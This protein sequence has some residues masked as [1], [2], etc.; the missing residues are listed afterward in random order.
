MNIS[1]LNIDK[2]IIHQI[3][4]RDEEGNKVE[5]TRGL[6]FITFDEDALQG[7]KSRVID[8]LGDGSKAVKMKILEH[9][10]SYVPFIA[11]NV[12]DKEGDEY[13]DETYLIANKLADAQTRRAIPG[14]IVVI[15][16]GNYGVNKRKFVGIIKADIYSAYEK[17]IDDATGQISLK[18]VEEILLTPS[19][20]LY[21]TAGFFQSSDVNDKDDLNKS[22]DVMIS[23]YQISKADGKAA[24]QYFYQHFLGC[25]YPETNA[26]A[27]KVFYEKTSDFLN[28]LDISAE[29]K[30]ALKNALVT[31]LKYEKSDVISAKDYAERFFDDAVKDVYLEYANEYGIPQT[32]FTR[33]NEHIESKLKTRKLNFSK[34]IKITAPADIFKNHIVIESTKGDIS[35]DGT[36][37]EWTKI[38]IKDKIILQ[39]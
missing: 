34:N 30:N 14:G 10:E 32:S 8:A 23:D 28:E 3:H 6:S 12:I 9:G 36:Q 27:T 13:I 4:Q 1:I 25:G 17:I 31:Y 33:D 20:K 24:A 11:T 18:F 7:F 21:K 16:T 35:D 37:A 26:R 22:W 15:F 39:E 2:I 5:P 29:K 38:L 19:T